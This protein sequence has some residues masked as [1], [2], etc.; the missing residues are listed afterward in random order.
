MQIDHRN[1]FPALLDAI[2]ATKAAEV[3]VA[4]GVFSSILLKAKLDRFYMV[5][6]WANP[7]GQRSRALALQVANTD[8]RC[9]V[10]ERASV[11]AAGMFTDG[12]L[13][14]VYIDA[15][16]EY[17][18]VAEDVRAWWPKASKVLAGHDY[19]LCN[20]GCAIAVGVMLAVEEWAA[21]HPEATLYVTGGRD[22]GYI[23][24]LRLATEATALRNPGLCGDRLPSW[25]FIKG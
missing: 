9:R 15:R 5:D 23:E 3:G 8:A 10:I 4:E 2:G 12:D 24:R 19:I 13:D 14:F 18:A 22:G 7:G 11:A 21:Q 25:Y 17:A 20:R 16:H 6:P 1:E